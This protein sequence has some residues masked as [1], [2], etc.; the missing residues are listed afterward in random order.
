MRRRTS[1]RIE[2]PA[3]LEP[4]LLAS[5]V[6]ATPLAD[7]FA[8]S[9]APPGV[10]NESAESVE[11]AQGTD[12]SVAEGG[13]AAAPPPARPL[14]KRGAS[15]TQ[16]LAG[17][18]HAPEEVLGERGRGAFLEYRIKWQGFSSSNSVTWELASKMSK[19]SGFEEVLR[20]FRAGPGGAGAGSLDLAVGWRAQAL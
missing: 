16:H 9:L 10:S 5:A 12:S 19:V 8:V 13:A 3:V 11:A 7:A 1:L 15:S 14:L 4:R 18:G 6:D 20:R 2:I 17:G